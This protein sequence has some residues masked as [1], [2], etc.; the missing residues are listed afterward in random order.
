MKVQT[1]GKVVDNPEG[2]TSLMAEIKAELENYLTTTPIA[3]NGDILRYWKNQAL[4][5]PKLAR[6]ARRLFAILATSSSSERVFSTAGNI[7][8]ERRTNLSAS[9]VEKLVYIKENLR[10]M[11]KMNNVPFIV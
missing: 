1:F 11:K 5:Y 3:D 6:F 2:V 10:Q 8:G 7:C 4:N 9:K